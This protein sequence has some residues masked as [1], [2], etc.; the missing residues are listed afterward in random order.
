MNA[1]SQRGAPRGA[2]RRVDL[3]IVVFIVG[4]GCLFWAFCPPIEDVAPDSST[5]QG[6]ARSLLADGT[7][8][9]NFVPHIQY[10]PGL[11]LILAAVSSVFG[12]AHLTYLH[13]QVVMSA[14]GLL[15]TYAFVSRWQDRGTAVATTV[16]LGVSVYLYIYTSV[17]LNSDVPYLA[18]SL[19]ALWAADRLTHAN[20]RASRWASGIAFTMLLLLTVLLRSVGMAMVAAFAAWIVVECVRRRGL[21]PAL[22]RFAL[23]LVVAG[24][25]VAGWSLWK[26]RI[27]DVATSGWGKG[28]EDA[29]FLADPHQP[30]RGLA[31][32]GDLLLRIPNNLTL[33]SAHL[34]ELVVNLRWIDP[35]WYSP[36]VVGMLA[37]VVAGVVWSVRH[38]PGPIEFYLLFYMAIYALW[39]YDV[40]ARFVLPI[41]PIAVVYAW[42]AVR[43]G[44]ELRGR[45]ALA[46]AAC[47]FVL[48]L[49]SSI[50]QMRTGFA[51]SVQARLSPLLWLIVGVLV[52]VRAARET[53]PRALLRRR[54]A[55]WP[56]ALA[57]TRVDA[58]AA[59]LLAA[60][61]ARG[62][63]EQF[64]T[65]RWFVAQDPA[66]LTHSAA[67]EA[68][69]WLKTHAAAGAV[70]MADQLA[71]VHYLTG[72][73]V[74][75]FPVTDD[76]APIVAALEA[77]CV[78]Y[79]VVTDS[80]LASAV[81]P[82]QTTR[83]QRVEAAEPRLLE[84]VADGREYR[85]YRVVGDARRGCPSPAPTRVAPTS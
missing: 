17:V 79:L 35:V 60:V 14:L 29:F 83:L 77:E 1:E 22:V 65:G 19:G 84:A 27:K 64:G 41:F 71:V 26:Q 20:T 28:Y 36:F 78:D 59:V 76:P 40:G 48:A 49:V 39:P 67:I 56:S 30:E 37:L 63:V 31:T 4:V 15:A 10:P 85:I 34:S 8:R 44:R 12:S 57:R 54:L 68:S 82:S 3:A 75:P 18:G 33:H 25:V 53:G 24:A 13:A 74:A 23:P 50:V 11:P 9:F 72:R 32:I 66:T 61:A 62:V 42:R 51:G 47:A 43:A 55:S 2:G 73:R 6:L 38:R 45:A 70:V 16:L 46:I 81:K 69:D 58:I 5:Y 21:A 7:Y 80:A 52:L